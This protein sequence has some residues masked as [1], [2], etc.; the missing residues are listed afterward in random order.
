[1]IKLDDKPLC[2]KTYKDP[3]GRVL[4]EKD[5]FYRIFCIDENEGDIHLHSERASTI[6]FIRENSWNRMSNH[7][8]GAPAPEFYKYFRCREGKLRSLIG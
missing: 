1:M 5:K 4:Y 3:N 7:I 8:Q 6:K 2:I